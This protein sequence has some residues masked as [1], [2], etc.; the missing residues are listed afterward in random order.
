MNELL[1]LLGGLG[2]F[3]TA[4]TIF[5][6]ALILFFPLILLTV[7]STIVFQKADRAWWE[8]LVPIYWNYVLVQ[9]AQKPWWWFLLLLLPVV[10]WVFI[11]FVYIEIAR[12]F[13]LEWPFAVGLTL[14]PIVFYPIL[15]WG[16]YE[17]QA[18]E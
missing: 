12:R 8:A 11:F 2:F 14:L 9:I 18:E 13:G 4:T 5:W 16:P 15:A 3:L 7:A 6:L 10:S 17:Y 1:L